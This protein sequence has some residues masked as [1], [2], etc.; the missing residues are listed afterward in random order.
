MQDDV[1]DAI[2]SVTAKGI[3]DPKR[4]CIVGVGYGGYVAL[5]GA[6][7]TPERLACAASINGIADLPSLLEHLDKA[8]DD[9]RYWHEHIGNASD[10]QVVR[11]SP[12]RNA[13]KARAP[14]L[15][16][17]GTRDSSVP[18]QQS[19]TMARALKQA[20]KPYEIIEL[21]DEDHWLSHNA[22]RIRM[23]AELERFLAKH[24]GPA[25]PSN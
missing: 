3:A 13:A 17:H 1:T 2:A 19:Q 15:L 14:I 11:A 12:S 25:G 18:V 10:K 7:L 6:T 9:S 23:L 16:I 20:G 22:T 5:A 4:V 21:Q 8:S 24:L